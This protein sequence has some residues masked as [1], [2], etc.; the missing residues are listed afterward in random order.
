M[1]RQESDAKA[2]VRKPQISRTPRKELELLHALADEMSWARHHLLDSGERDPKIV[3]ALD[4]IRETF[5]LEKK[6]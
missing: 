2:V 3:K 6:A 4:K 1:A 5:Q